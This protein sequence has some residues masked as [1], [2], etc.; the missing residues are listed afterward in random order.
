[1]DRGG[2]G[3]REGGREGLDTGQLNVQ[4]EVGLVGGG[5]DFALPA[6][7]KGQTRL[8]LICPCMAT[9]ARASGCPTCFVL[10]HGHGHAHGH[11]RV[12]E[13]RDNTGVGRWVAITTTSLV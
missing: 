8:G 6:A 1:M 4:G 11:N 9:A 7:S 10:A 13:C 12:H 3:D 5:E 2:E